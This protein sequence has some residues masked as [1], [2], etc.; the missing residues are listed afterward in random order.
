[1][2]GPASQSNIKVVQENAE[3][4]APHAA[5]ALDKRLRHEEAL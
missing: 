1:M 3:K 5:L 4:A 2:V